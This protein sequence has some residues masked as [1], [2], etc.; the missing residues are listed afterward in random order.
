MSSETQSNTAYEQQIKLAIKLRNYDEAYRLLQD[1]SLKH[2]AEG[3]VLAKELADALFSRGREHADCGNH[4][5]A[6]IDLNRSI[7]LGGAAPQVVQLRNVLQAQLKGDVPA[8]PLEH[9]HAVEP[10][11]DTME[12]HPGRRGYSAHTHPPASKYFLW[13][14]GVGTFLIASGPR[15]TLG[16]HGS[17]KTP[18]IALSGSFSG[19]AGEIIRTGEQYLF[20]AYDAA[21]VNGTRSSEKVLTSGDRI[22]LDERT[23]LDFYLPSPMNSTALLT[24]PPPYL[25]PG[26]VKNAV[27]LDTFLI[28]GKKGFA[29]IKAPAEPDHVVVYEKEGTLWARTERPPEP[30]HISPFAGGGD[31]KNKAQA[32]NECRLE[33]GKRTLIN[34]L[35]LTV[36]K[37]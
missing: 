11:A 1:A 28:I 19:L 34:R 23:A 13:I 24:L 8:A 21:D 2:Q 22:S 31:N 17:S 27:L 30:G 37:G 36:T 29:H 15:V 20:R 5:E 6:M 12:T 25:I 10:A 4:A 16:R 14:D 18:D 9:H 26:P 33:F 7:E 32:Q 35:G 3:Q